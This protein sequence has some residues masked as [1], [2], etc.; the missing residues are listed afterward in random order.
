MVALVFA[1][2]L[3]FI[4]PAKAARRSRVLRAA[5]KRHPYDLETLSAIEGYPI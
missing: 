5:D 1:A 3:D 4:P 2:P